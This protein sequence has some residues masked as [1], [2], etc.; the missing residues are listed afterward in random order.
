M[1][2]ADAKNLNNTVQNGPFDGEQSVPD[3]AWHLAQGIVTDC[4]QLI[5]ILTP[6]HMQAMKL[7]FSA[8]LETAIGIASHFKIADVIEERG[9]KATVQ[10]LADTVGTDAAKLGN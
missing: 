2:G 6:T 5:S 9:G 8:G 10:E 1:L 3:E 4:Y 7:A